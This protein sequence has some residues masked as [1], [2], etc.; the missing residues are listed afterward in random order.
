MREW[1]GPLGGLLP[2]RSMPPGV[3]AAR[4]ARVSSRRALDGSVA[5][6][7]LPRSMREYAWTLTQA[8]SEDI[9]N[10]YALYQGVHGIGPFWL[11]D[12]LAA[13]RNM[14]SPGA[15]TPGL[16]A[17]LGWSGPSTN[18]AR[19]LVYADG[20]PVSSAVVP[21][22]A[23]HTYTGAAEATGSG[24]VQLEWVDS[25]E[26][27]LSTS[28]GEFGTDRR[29][30]SGVAPDGAAGARMVLDP[31]TSATFQ[32]PQLTETDGPVEWFAGVGMPRV[33]VAELGETYQAA[34][35]AQGVY[36]GDYSVRLVEVGSP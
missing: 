26:E 5:A 1:I 9:A 36:R 17:D 14:L 6:Q 13:G 8:D 3:E 20:G 27:V 12:R 33:V 11:Y 34:W 21:V 19:G 35:K 2:M 22:L 18:P 4:P 16:S 7:I 29:T 25:D 23:S 32:R 15:A 10:L 28:S 30:I 31:E 24:R